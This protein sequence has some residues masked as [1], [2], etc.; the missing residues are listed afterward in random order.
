VPTRADSKD[1]YELITTECEGNHGRKQAK[2]AISPFGNTKG[3]Q[4]GLAW[5]KRN[6][7]DCDG[8]SLH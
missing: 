1:A 2:K 8:E 3:F 4:A 7:C 6:L 5:H